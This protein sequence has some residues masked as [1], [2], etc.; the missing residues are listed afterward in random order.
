[1]FDFGNIHRQ[2]LRP[3]RFTEGCRHLMDGMIFARNS[4]DDLTMH[5]LLP[6]CLCL[7]S[8]PAWSAT[9]APQNSDP[10]GG[11]YQP[12]W[13]FAYTNP[14]YNIKPIMDCT[15]DGLQDV[16]MSS[17]APDLPFIVFDGQ[18]GLIWFQ[19]QIP[20]RTDALVNVGDF[21]GDGIGDLL[22]REPH[23][24]SSGLNENG[25]IQLIHGGDGAVLWQIDGS[26]DY[27]NLGAICRTLDLAGD[28]ILDFLAFASQEYLYAFSGQSG[29]RLWT[30]T[31]GTAQWVTKVHDLSS[32]GIQEIALSGG[33]GLTLLNGATGLVHWSTA[34]ALGSNPGKSSFLSSDLNADGIEDLILVDTLLRNTIQWPGAGQIQA[35]DGLSG[36][37][38]WIAKGTKANGGLGSNAISADW[39]ADGV[40][41]FLSVSDSYQALVDGSDGHLV[42][43]TKTNMTPYPKPA[44]LYGDMNQDGLEDLIFRVDDPV[45][46]L[47]VQAGDTGAVLWEIASLDPPQQWKNIATADLDG[48][49]TLEILATM[50]DASGTYSRSGIVVAFDGASGM[51]LWRREGEQS[52]ARLG[53]HMMTVQADQLPGLDVLI[54]GNAA[55]T[56]PGIL[57]CSGLDGSDLW[58][59][60][61]AAPGT[62]K[63]HEVDLNA[64]GLSELLEFRKIKGGNLHITRIDPMLGA[65]VVQHKVEDIFGDIP[66]LGSLNDI[67]GDGVQE[68]MVVARDD[69]P[70][71]RLQ[72]FPGGQSSYFSGLK[73]SDQQL[74]ISAGGTIEITVDFHSRQGNRDF[75]L[76]LSA[77]GVGPTTVEGSKVPLTRDHWLATTYLENYP[78]GYFTTATGTLDSA[79]DSLISFNALPAQINPSLAGT[80][81][82]LAVVTRISPGQIE[83]SSGS[84]S[85]LI[86]P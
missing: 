72:V 10:V 49:G 85:V 13:E 5:R 2:K 81:M 51:E 31:P 78:A 14:T 16:L 6:L 73:L 82:Y 12:L 1:M 70:D 52:S 29:A 71:W 18:T 46:T 42:W 34:T 62:V 53:R 43:Y 74:S 68:I 44:F 66:Y 75:Q 25:R 35:F 63:W 64:D 11:W 50:P 39:T 60:P 58:R 4:S 86:L 45:R 79:G 40:A 69:T 47:R 15:G 61:L 54:R 57:A 17:G 36:S 9:L 20:N 33:G 56:D 76:L 22:F 38:L 55:G 8:T 28:G 37:S 7:L 59:L 80:I 19:R 48:N 84:E 21:D 30:Q 32:D 83:F 65:V 67:D 3:I 27:Q 26:Y 77:S 41:D 24:S 23:T